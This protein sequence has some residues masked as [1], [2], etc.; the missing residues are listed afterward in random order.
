MED[1]GNLGFGGPTDAITANSPYDQTVTFSDDSSNGDANLKN[2]LGSDF[3]RPSTPG[4]NDTNGIGQFSGF[5]TFNHNF[6]GGE[7]FGDF[8]F[9]N[10]ANNYS[11]RPDTTPVAKDNFTSAPELVQ[12]FGL[13]TQFQPPPVEITPHYK[14]FLPDLIPAIGA[15]DAFIKVPRPDD[16]IEPLGL[17]VLDEPTIGCSDPQVMKMQLRE[18]YGLVAGNEGD[19]YI[20]QIKDLDKNQKALDTFLESYEEMVRA[21][22]APT[23][24][25]NFEVPDEQDLMEVWPEEFD[26]AL[27]SI[28]LPSAD[29]DLTLE[30]YSKVICSICDIPVKGNIIESLHLL[31]TVYTLFA[32]HQHFQN[33]DSQA[34]SEPA[35]SLTV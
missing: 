14:P 31:F 4:D 23:M 8:T 34:T 33:E 5:G 20:G 12:L 7:P 35:E 2:Q 3:G 22:P 13:I 10:S 28:P 30:E 9:G 17:T 21:R 32:G 16:E 26:K 29:M 18:K 27:N 11:P 6:G 25:Y 15:I 19:G 1:Y 24:S